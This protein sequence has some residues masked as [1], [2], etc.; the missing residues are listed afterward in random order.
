MK[1]GLRH[2]HASQPVTGE[3]MNPFE[4]KF[5]GQLK[6]RKLVVRGDRIL[7]AVSG[8]PDSLA[9]LLLLHASLPAMHCGLAV[10]HCNF[11]L[12][13]DESDA[14]EV[15]VSDFCRRLGIECF[16][17][18][19][20]ARLAAS[21]LKKSIEES[22]RHLRYGF[23][24]QLAEEHGFTRIATGHHVN[25]NAETILFNL[26][27][28]VSPPGLVG[29]R[30]RNGMIIRPM[31]LLHKDEI[32][33]YLEE[34]GVVARRDSSNDLDDYDRNFIRNRVI[35]LI[36]ER[37]AHKLLPSLRRLSEQAGELEEFLERYFDDLAAREP[38]VVLHEGELDVPALKRLGVFEQKEVFKRALKELDAPV[39]A[40]TLQKLT[41]LLRS[42]PGKT[43]QSAGKLAVQWRGSKLLFT[44]EK[45]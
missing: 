13:G 25:D 10:A 29:I 24:A 21:E 18:R 5:L 14:D 37:F 2:F 22:A 44:S 26:F 42:R 39:D 32:Q 43:V 1:N 19:F 31:L 4:K 30:E 35:P 3:R 17:I 15:F 20:D 11:S 6:Q 7:A 33:R 23:F 41:E 28:G 36:E 45:P 40:L 16:S 38:G 9:M 12:R 8:G 27:R 34:K